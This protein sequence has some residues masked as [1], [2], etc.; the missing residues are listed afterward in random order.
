[1]IKFRGQLKAIKIERSIKEKNE[2]IITEFLSEIT[3]CIRVAATI[4]PIRQLN[5]KN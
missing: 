2:I 4:I 1:M 5:R 3:Q